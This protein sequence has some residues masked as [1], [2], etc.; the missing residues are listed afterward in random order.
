MV[1]ILFFQRLQQLAVVGAHNLSLVELLVVLVVVLETKVAQ[2][3]LELHLKAWMVAL[4]V[5]AFS[6]ALA[7][8]ELLRLESHQQTA[9]VAL[10]GA[11]YQ[12]TLLVPQ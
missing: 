9:L 1:Q 8:V 6:V 12:M 2:V 11:V 4:A 3:E 10:V 7:V 5:R